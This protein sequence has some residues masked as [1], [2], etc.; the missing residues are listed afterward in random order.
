MLDPGREFMNTKPIMYVK[1]G[2]RPAKDGRVS[3]QYVYPMSGRRFN[4]R[5]KIER[6]EADKNSGDYQVLF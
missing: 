1:K 4:K 5:V 6:Y 2:G 3:V